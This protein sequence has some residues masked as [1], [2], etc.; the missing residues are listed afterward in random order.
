MMVHELLLVLGET[1][2]MAIWHSVNQAKLLEMPWQNKKFIN[3]YGVLNL[4]QLDMFSDQKNI[5]LAVFSV[6]G[7]QFLTM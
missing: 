2:S 6:D 3:G 1:E 4:H 7:F 5:V